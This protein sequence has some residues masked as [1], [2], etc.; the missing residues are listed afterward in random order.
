MTRQPRTVA[1]TKVRVTEAPVG[2][3][4]RSCIALWAT[5][6]RDPKAR[7]AE[8]ASRRIGSTKVGAGHPWAPQQRRIA[9]NESQCQQQISPFHGYGVPIQRESVEINVITRLIPN[10]WCQI[11]VR[12]GKTRVPLRYPPLMDAVRSDDP[13]RRPYAI[14][15]ALEA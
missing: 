11:D 1:M 4:T 12:Y 5:A 13:A 2:T 8:M 7:A 10:A 14:D 6:S 3:A 9:D 15:L